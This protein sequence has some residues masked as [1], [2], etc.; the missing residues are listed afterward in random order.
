MCF[1]QFSF[2]MHVALNAMKYDL[3]LKFLHFIW[4]IKEKSQ[5]FFVSIETH[6][7]IDLNASH[8]YVIFLCLR[9][10]SIFVVVARCAYIR[11]TSLTSIEMRMH[12]YWCESHRHDHFH[13]SIEKTSKKKKEKHRWKRQKNSFVCV[14]HRKIFLLIRSAAHAAIQSPFIMDLVHTKTRK[15]KRIHRHLEPEQE[16]EP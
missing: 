1:H 9:S 5:F 2:V 12:R 6:I 10:A 16:L 15:P 4:K 8:L 3:R 14:V 7:K 11:S 13:F